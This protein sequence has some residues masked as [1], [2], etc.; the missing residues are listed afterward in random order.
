PFRWPRD[1]RALVAFSAVAGLVCLLAFGPER[2]AGAGLSAQRPAAPAVAAAVESLDPDDLA[3]QRQF[4]D[5]MKQ[6]A[7]QTSDQALLEMSRELDALLDKAEKGEIG[8]Q[9][10]ITRMEALE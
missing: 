10:L 1:L 4:V 8:K 2:S 5:D 7:E 9:E 6:L 3:Y